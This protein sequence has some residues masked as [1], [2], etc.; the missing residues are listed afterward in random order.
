MIN[1]FTNETAPLSDRELDCI[2][3]VENELKKAYGKDRAVYNDRLRELTGLSSARIRKVINHIRVNKIVPC[4]VASSKGY[5]IAETEQELIEYE[6]SLRRR[7]GA[8]RE[9]RQAIADQR[10]IRYSGGTQGRLF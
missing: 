4:L 10:M 8:I 5:Y 1:G 6:E 9:V 3:V 2:P 7:E